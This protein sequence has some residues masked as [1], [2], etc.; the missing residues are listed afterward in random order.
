LT[1]PSDDDLDEYWL[2]RSRSFGSVAEQYDRYRPGYP[3]ALFAAIPGLRSGSRVLEAGAGTGRASVALAERGAFVTSVEPDPDMARVNRQR[4]ASL[5]VTV[6]VAKFEDY[7]PEPG[8]FDIVCCAQAWHWVNHEAGG[9]VAR[10]ALK[11]NGTIAL[12]ANGPRDFDGPVWL[13]IAAAYIDEAPNL[14]RQFP[15]LSR[16]HGDDPWPRLSGFSD[17]TVQSFDWEEQYTVDQYIGLLGTQSDHILLDDVTRTR[18][19]GRITQAIAK[20][21]GGVHTYRYT[22]ELWTAQRE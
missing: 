4:T 16:I 14:H 13:A 19:F 2:M 9:R 18:L 1:E 20:Y 22:A 8:E 10:N 15:I 11:P 3:D 21:G 6:I 7:E 12:F 5:P 17:W